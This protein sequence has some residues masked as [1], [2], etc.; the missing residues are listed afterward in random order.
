MSPGKRRARAREVARKA[1]YR[2]AHGLQKPGRQPKR[3]PAIDFI[4]MLLGMREP[5][6]KG[7][8]AARTPTVAAELVAAARAKRQ[9]RARQRVAFREAETARQ[10]AR[11]K[12]SRCAAR[13]RRA[14]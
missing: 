6:I 7:P 4:E 5:R 11:E 9:R 2:K 10:A 1:A 8:K 3:T 13:M 14:A 12:A